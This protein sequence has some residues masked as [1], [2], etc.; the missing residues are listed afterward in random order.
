MKTKI[1]IFGVDFLHARD[2][3]PAV[4]MVYNFEIQYDK[5]R[6]NCVQD[7]LYMCVYHRS[8][9]SVVHIMN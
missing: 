1:Y 8:F 7:E 3:L 9:G 6:T 2:L 5:I 4:P